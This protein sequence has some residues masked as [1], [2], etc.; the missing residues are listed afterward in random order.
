[1]LLNYKGWK[2]ISESSKPDVVYY[3]ILAENILFTDSEIQ[4]SIQRLFN[5]LQSCKFEKAEE[6]S[7]STVRKY[8]VYFSLI[9]DQDFGLFSELGIAEIS[10]L[11]FLLWKILGSDI[12]TIVNKNFEVVRTVNRPNGNHLITFYNKEKINTLDPNEVLDHIRLR[13][14]KSYSP[15]KLESHDLSNYSELDKLLE[16][17]ILTRNKNSDFINKLTILFSKHLYY[18][19]VKLKDFNISYYQVNISDWVNENTKKLDELEKVAYTISKG[20]SSEEEIEKFIIDILELQKGFTK[21]KEGYL[22][23]KET[24]KL[25]VRTLDIFD[26]SNITDDELDRM[27]EKFKNK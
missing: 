20:S 22:E 17:F 7:N 11:T 14:A 2:N 1:M 24:S 8:K 5:N 15:L 26:Y 4:E 19:M 25:L 10:E 12:K 16:E 21:I 3:T 13:L 27:A 18:E 6:V 9:E 23:Y